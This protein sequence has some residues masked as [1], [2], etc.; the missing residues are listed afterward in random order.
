MRGIYLG[1]GSNIGDRAAYLAFVKHY[2]TICAESFIYES[3]ALLPPDAPLSWNKPFLNQVLEIDSDLSPEALLA[4]VKQIEVLAGR[5]DRGRWAPRELDIDILAYGISIIETADL[6][7]PHASI[8]SRDFVLLPLRDIASSWPSI[9]AM[10]ANLPEIKARIWHKRMQL[11]GI[12][13][14]TPDSFSDDGMLTTED[15]VKRFERLVDD[16]ADIIDIGAESTRPGAVALAHQEEWTRLEA[17]LQAI[18]QHPLRQR[19]SISVDTRHWQTAERALMMGAD[20][21]NDVSGLSDASMIALLK[22]A[23][24]DIVVMHS[25]TI[26]ADKNAT[27]PENVD[28][29]AV[30]LRWKKRMVSLGISEQR[31]IFDCG[32]GF[33]KTIAQ[34]RTLI[35]QFGE[36]KASGGRWLMGHSRKSFLNVP[37][38]M[39]D[40]ATLEISKQLAV[41]GVDIIRI[42]DVAGHY[43]L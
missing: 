23:L 2:F 35:E 15:V 11:M 41:Q 10:I 33:G 29:I 19:V 27:L 9:D 13:N 21:I 31:L 22:D 4:E 1:I 17:P 8:A 30:V 7:L 37:M 43:G 28:P 42:H 18:M 34:S 36:L 24:C 38:E 40:A 3:P 26:P 12:I 25:L 6:K 16:G 14:I 39:R 5:K 32:I 20:I